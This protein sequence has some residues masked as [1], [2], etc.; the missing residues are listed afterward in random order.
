MRLALALLL[1]GCGFRP[2]TD[3]A[4]GGAPD[5]AMDLA[6]LTD[7]NGGGNDDLSTL[8]CPR[9]YLIMNVDASMYPL[10]MRF[11]LAGFTACQP[12]I[13]GHA[14]TPGTVAAAFIPPSA[15]AVTGVAG[16]MLIDAD[17]DTPIWNNAVD[18]LDVLPLTIGGTT[19]VA[20]ARGTPGGARQVNFVDTYSN[21]TTKVAHYALDGAGEPIGNVFGVA[22]DPYKPGSILAMQEG[23]TPAAATELDPAAMTTSPV[24]PYPGTTPMLT[25]IA[26]V[27]NGAILRLAWVDAK[28]NGLFWA[29]YVGAAIS[30]QGPISCSGQSCTLVDAVPDPRDSTT[31]FALCDYGGAQTHRSILKM[32]SSSCTVAYDG[33]A[34]PPDLLAT[35]LSIAP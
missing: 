14:L 5:A 2:L 28:S 34:L 15:V 24:I 31:F 12:L 26:A 29:N 8:S 21:G 18:G 23:T 6:S 35:D 11:S 3:G 22:A 25:T 27:A 20:I 10:V 16:T 1:A 33:I 32:T 30:A 19:L 13:A 17:H 4:D 9:P 7:G